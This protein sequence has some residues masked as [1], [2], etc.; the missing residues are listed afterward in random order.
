VGEEVHTVPLWVPRRPE[1]LEV[2]PANDLL[3]G[4]GRLLVLKGG[5]RET[6]QK[7]KMKRAKRREKRG[8][9]GATLTRVIE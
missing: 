4:D 6:Y 2:I 5:E 7:T 8:R 1:V 9:D 3:P